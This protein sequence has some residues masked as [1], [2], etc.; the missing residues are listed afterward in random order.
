MSMI[1]DSLHWAYP[2][3]ILLLLVLPLAAWLVFHFRRRRQGLHFSAFAIIRAA[4]GDLSQYGRYI[5]PFLRLLALILLIVILVRPQSEIR[6]VKRQ[7]NSLDILLVLDLSESMTAQDIR[8]NRLEAAKRVLARFIRKREQDR[9]GI[10]VFSGVPVAL[11]P[12]TLDHQIVIHALNEADTRTVNLEGTAM[13]DALLLAA[14]RL[15][16]RDDSGGAEGEAPPQP[17]KGKV[18]ILATDGV[19]NR[20]LDPLLAA[21]LLAL[22]GIKLYT[23]SLGGE[24][25]VLRY[26]TDQRG[27]YV[28]LRDVY[29]RLQFWERPDEEMLAQMAETGRGRHYRAGNLDQFQ[30]IMESID[31]LEKTTVSLDRHQ[32][33]QEEY[34]SFLL[35]AL[36]LLLAEAL[37]RF[38]RF[39]TLL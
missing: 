31:R 17:R 10:I 26:E 9:L 15:L 16:L 21:R 13:G 8:P 3:F 11:A 4:A 25:P 1:S 19:N 5:I 38:V 32:A 37:L 30:S 20:G 23:V 2:I 22:K 14:N 7:M 24:K 36:A 29:G 33:F 27:R 18:I 34:S 28:P 39:R 35:A 6:L 12:L